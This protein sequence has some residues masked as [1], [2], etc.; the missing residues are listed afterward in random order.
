MLILVE[1]KTDMSAIEGG[2]DIIES[3][4]G[5]IALGKV[6]MNQKKRQQI[7]TVFVPSKEFKKW[8]KLKP[9]DVYREVRSRVK[10][11]LT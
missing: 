11:H 7:E 2:V 6:S 9:K 3:T 1:I 5:T 10:Q 4:H 8:A